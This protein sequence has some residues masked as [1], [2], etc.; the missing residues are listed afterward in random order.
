MVRDQFTI[1]HTLVASM[2]VHRAMQKLQHLAS[3][4][5]LTE[6]REGERALAKSC[7]RHRIYVANSNQPTESKEDENEV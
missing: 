2:L 4:F 3:D 5:P 6:E 7:A 1:Y